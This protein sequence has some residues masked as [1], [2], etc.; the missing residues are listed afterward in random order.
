MNTNYKFKNPFEKVNADNELKE[1]IIAKIKLENPSNN[2]LEKIFNED[3][4]IL[5]G[6]VFLGIIIFVSIFFLLYKE[7]YITKNIFTSKPSYILHYIPSNTKKMIFTSIILLFYVGIIIYLNV[8]Y[9]IKLDDIKNYLNIESSKEKK[10]YNIEQTLNYLMKKHENTRTSLYINYILIVLMNIFLIILLNRSG[11]VTKDN[12]M[13]MASHAYS[14]LLNKKI[15]NQNKNNSQ[16]GGSIDLTMEQLDDLIYLMSDKK[17]VNKT[18]KN[19]IELYHKK[20]ND[21]KE[22]NNPNNIIPNS[23][24]LKSNNCENEKVSYTINYDTDMFPKSFVKNLRKVYKD[25]PRFTTKSLK[26]TK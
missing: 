3:N 22:F 16:K 23:K 26:K 25:N 6:L 11:S 12:S 21:E 10:N 8:N 7:S 24:L 19:Y 18:L 20:Y 15:D 14:K 13:I 1:K 2:N 9:P 17:Y 5:I 4:S